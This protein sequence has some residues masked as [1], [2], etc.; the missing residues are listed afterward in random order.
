MNFEL[1]GDLLV[2]TIPI[3]TTGATYALAA[4][5]LYLT[6]KY[7]HN[8]LTQALMILDQIV[9]DVVKELNQTIVL[10]LKKA[11]IDNKLTPDEIAQIRGKAVEMVI[12]RLGSGIVQILLKYF[13]GLTEFVITK[14]EAAVYDLK[15]NK[16]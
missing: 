8:K 1:L 11:N 3:V 7:H 15:N 9:I 16:K 13:G 2:V 6:N 4:F 10:E 14:V 12:S 5:G